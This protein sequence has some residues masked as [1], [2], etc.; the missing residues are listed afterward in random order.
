MVDK[1]LEDYLKDMHKYLGNMPVSEKIDIISELKSQMIDMQEER[2][3]SAEDIVGHFGSAKVL[4]R[5]YLGESISVDGGFSLKKLLL[6]LSYWTLSS[7]GVLVII[8]V[9]GICSVT[10]IGSGIVTPF[11][12]TIK[13]VA[14]TMGYDIPEIGIYM[15]NVVFSPLS[16]FFLCLLMGGLLILLGVLCWKVMLLY[17]RYVNK[18]KAGIVG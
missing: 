12:G 4:A 13:L 5:A 2:C 6:L 15:E 7:L 8:P 16:T 18:N 9:F 10:F 3:L 14:Y 11:M 17:I 1:L